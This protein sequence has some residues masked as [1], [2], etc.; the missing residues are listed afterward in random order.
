M[1]PVSLRRRSAA[2]LHLF[3]RAAPGFTLFFFAGFTLQAFSSGV[4]EEARPGS[5][6][7]RLDQTK[8]G[9]IAVLFRAVGG[10]GLAKSSKKVNLSG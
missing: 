4:L 2:R 10:E 7:R 1:K 3:L 9:A 5:D 8:H 6:C